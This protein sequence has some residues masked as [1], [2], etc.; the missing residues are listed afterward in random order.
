MVHDK[1][2]DLKSFQYAYQKDGVTYYS[3]AFNNI[4]LTLMMTLDKD[5]KIETFRFTPQRTD[6]PK[7]EESNF[8]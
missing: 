7:T 3:T 5:S 8:F 6:T 2:G 1:F 4:L